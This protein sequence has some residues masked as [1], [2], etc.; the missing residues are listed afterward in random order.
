M[1]TTLSLLCYLCLCLYG[2]SGSPQGEWQVSG[3]TEVLTALQKSNESML[4]AE[5]MEMEMVQTITDLS[6]N[7]VVA[8]GNGFFKRKDSLFVHSYVLGV[9]TIQN[10]DCKLMVDSTSKT[11]MLNAPVAS[12]PN[13]DLANIKGFFN[14]YPIKQVRKRVLDNG[15][16]EYEI[17]FESSSYNPVEKIVF[18][19]SDSWMITGYAMILNKSPYDGSTNTRSEIR[20]RYFNHQVNHKIN[21]DEFGI[22]KILTFKQGEP[23][24]AKDYA[25]YEFVNTLHE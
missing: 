10:K 11:I 3:K 25:S 14:L 21:A 13:I 24:L 8:E 16:K 20:I 7:K 17:L 4:N 18:S 9:E 22:S 6:A 23:I 12:T 2:L 1:R 19:H 15:D 5:T